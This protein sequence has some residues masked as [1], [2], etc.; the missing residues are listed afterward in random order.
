MGKSKFHKITSMFL[1]M[2]MMLTM[3]GMTA[4]AEESTS[5]WSKYVEINHKKVGCEKNVDVA[6][7]I[8]SDG[9]EI[10]SG[11]Y[12]LG[13]GV[14]TH[15]NVS[16]KD[17]YKD[18]YEI[19]SI[20]AENAWCSKGYYNEGR[21]KVDFW[22]WI[23]ICKQ[24]KLII[25]LK[26]TGHIAGEPQVTEPTCTEPGLE[27][28]FCTECGEK[29]SEKTLDPLGHDWGDWERTK[30][31][32]CTEEGVETR[33]CKRCGISEDRPVS[34][35]DHKFGPWEDRG[36][37]HLHVCTLCNG[38][39]DEA[40]HVYGDW[41]VTKEAT[42][43]EDGEQVRTCEV[44]GHQDTELIPKKGSEITDPT[45]PADPADP[46]DSSDDENTSD[47]SN[48]KDKKASSEKTDAK[49]ADSKTVKTGDENNILLWIALMALAGAGVTGGVI[50][51]KKS[52]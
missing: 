50:L 47:S 20:E 51:K 38:E 11:V 7:T 25:N 35:I 42:E 17:E 34:M 44:C 49:K 22:Y 8:K 31:P 6:V 41:T 2:V 15:L 18:A 14:N 26:H 52:F 3:L 9:K 39:F 48:S 23:K 45:D 40:E 4:F 43:T 30:E 27:E 5:D 1:V 24:P 21:S 37:T 16:L 46:S 28:V 13:V 29:L 12:N 10:A 36:E 19:E 33:V 32:T